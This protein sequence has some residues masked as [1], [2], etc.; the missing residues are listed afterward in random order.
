MLECIDLRQQI[1]WAMSHTTIS[2]CDVD[3]VVRFED[4]LDVQYRGT[5]PPWW[6]GLAVFA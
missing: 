6:G 4:Q 5:I 2:H 3:A 1:G